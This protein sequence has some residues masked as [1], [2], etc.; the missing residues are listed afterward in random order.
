MKFIKENFIYL[1]ICVISIFLCL[2]IREINGSISL[3]RRVDKM[4]SS[5]AT[6]QAN[7]QFIIDEIGVL[8][9]YNDDEIVKQ[10]IH[11]Q[12]DNQKVINNRY[13]WI[14]EVVNWEGGED[15]AIRFVNQNLMEDEGSF[16]DTSYTDLV[17]DFPYLKQLEGVKENSELF[18]SY[19]FKN[20][21]DD[22]KVDLKHSY[23]KL[24]DDYNWIIGCGIPD[25]DLY[26][27]LN[28]D[29]ALHDKIALIG[30]LS[31]LIIAFIL[32]LTIYE[33]KKR[34]QEA[35]QLRIGKSSANAK[36]E[37]KTEFLSTVS[38]ELRTPLNAIIGLNELLSQNMDDKIQVMEYSRKIDESSHM[39]LSL[40][41]DVL[42]MAAIEKGQLK[43]ANEEFNVN[44]LIHS[45]SDIYFNLAEKKNLKFE[46]EVDDIKK[47]LLLGDSYRIRQIILNLLSNSLKFTK[48]G[49]LSLSVKEEFNEDFN[50][51]SVVL[52]IVV[53]DT[54]CGM[55]EETIARLFEQFE[56][57][58]ASVVR[59]YGGSGLGLSITKH[60]VDAMN[61]SIQVKSYVDNGTV[62]NVKLPLAASKNKFLATFYENKHRIM[63]IGSNKENAKQLTIIFD[64]WNIKY[65]IIESSE[66]AISLLNNN[67]KYYN[68]FIIDY[69][70]KSFDSIEL[71]KKIRQ[72]KTD[73]T[74]VMITGYNVIEVRKRDIGDVDYLIQKPFIKEELFKKLSCTYCSKLTEVN[75]FDSSKLNG[76]SILL[77]DDNSIN[78]LVASNLL[79]S[80]GIKVTTAENGQNAVSF[81]KANPFFDLVL[82]D[83]RMPIMDGL[84]AT[85]RIRKFNSDI[86]IIALSANAFADDIKKSK[87]AGMNYHISKPI[88][89]IQ[90]YKII[91]E[92]VVDKRLQY[93]IIE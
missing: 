66:N 41:N 11:D 40:I 8:R 64:E 61:G 21:D 7:V 84:T 38:H 3:D 17:G 85:R 78:L 83:I 25:A 79:K 60:L 93:K 43:I 13:M 74:I 44:T 77:V 48:K 80:V 14:N 32:C 86:P 56:Q 67:K 87:E 19:Y 34:L 45:V 50:E 23:V 16:L 57:A 55:K 58:D 52:N 62:F 35:T 36:S 75:K 24:Y 30:E 5:S 53:T 33:R 10:I 31:I 18:Y 71:S 2:F 54:G 9:K 39:L 26:R 91:M 68:S 29:E 89:K 20:Y 49:K 42:D 51:D 46:L 65:D 72:I 12:I 6:N 81:V 63:I 70:D 76:L 69:E 27:K 47:E 82:M 59:Q 1:T 90:L 37:A 4:E 92:Y 15:F 28:S 73:S 22:Y 88:D